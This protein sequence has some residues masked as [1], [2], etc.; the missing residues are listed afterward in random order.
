MCRF[1][2]FLNKLKDQNYYVEKFLLQAETVKNTPGL[3][4][5][6]DFDFHKDGYGFIF[7]KNNN[8]SIYKSSLLFKNDNNNLFIK[9]KINNSEKLIGHIRA[10]KHHFV[11]DICYNN[12]HP[13]WFKDNY[14]VHNGS[15][16]PF[17]NYFFKKFISAKYLE[18]IK[19][20]TD[21]ELLFYIFLSINDKETSILNSWKIFFKLLYKFYYENN[22]VISANIVF[23]NK[24][25]LL[26]SRFINNNEEPP[27]LYIDTNLNIVSSEP[28]S[29]N[30][31][32]IERN[33]SIIVNINSNTKNI[34]NL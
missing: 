7:Y 19:G 22:I 27:S 26:I 3:D 33:K 12:T 6:R 25:V 18:H 5:D 16:Y 30:Y 29:N 1:I 10:T 9:E 11:D 24:Q 21:S 28:I 20:K 13:F 32:I 15:V 34:E 4:N 17:N 31:N 2:V 14:W 8:F 23:C